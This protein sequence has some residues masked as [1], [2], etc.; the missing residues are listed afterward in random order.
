MCC[1]LLCSVFS[2]LCACLWG[3][4]SILYGTGVLARHRGLDDRQGWIPAALGIDGPLLP[5][6][7]CW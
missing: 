6:P 2:L 7:K 1:T 3:E 5:L 4:E